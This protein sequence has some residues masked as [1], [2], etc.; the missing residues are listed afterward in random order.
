[1]THPTP[2]FLALAI[3]LP[4]LCIMT[5]AGAGEVYKWKDAKGVTHYGDVPPARANAKL[6]S[7]RA[8]T[9]KPVVTAV[10]VTEDPQCVTA[11][12]NLAL[13]RGKAPV[14]ID[15]N[16]DGKPDSAMDAT[17]R[18]KQANL[19]QAGVDAYCKAAPVAPKA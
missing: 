11:R 13:L 8:S 5:A 3:A 16:K 1:M 7:V 9:P 6:S 2:R 4:L 10:T 14:G 19:A 12:S 15:T 18:A 17:E